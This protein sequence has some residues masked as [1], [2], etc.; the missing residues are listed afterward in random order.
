MLTEFKQNKWPKLDGFFWCCMC[1]R[2]DA[3]VRRDVCACRGQALMPSASRIAH[4]LTLLRQG[5]SLKLKRTGAARLPG[6]EAL[7]SFHLPSPSSL[8]HAFWATELMS[9]C[10]CGKCFTDETTT[11]APKSVSP[12]ETSAKVVRVFVSLRGKPHPLPVAPSL[13]P[14]P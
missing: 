9:A 7:G 10:L 2:G 1:A 5:L 12:G 14:P 8:F 11:S 6:Q 4:H 13:L 3:R